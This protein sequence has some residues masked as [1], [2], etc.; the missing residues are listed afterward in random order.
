VGT[1]L[2]QIDVLVGNPGIADGIDLLL[3]Q[4]AGRNDS[5]A[6]CPRTLLGERRFALRSPSQHVWIGTRRISARHDACLFAVD[7]AIALRR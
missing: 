1:V 2:V 4:F 6:A 7:H 5:A 3:R